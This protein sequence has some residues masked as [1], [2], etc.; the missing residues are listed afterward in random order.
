MTSQELKK[1]SGELDALHAELEI[2]GQSDC[3]IE[4]SRATALSLRVDYLE[5]RLDI[6]IKH[7]PKKSFLKVLK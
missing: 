6:A 1:I 4:N 2:I 3:P 5:H 7:A